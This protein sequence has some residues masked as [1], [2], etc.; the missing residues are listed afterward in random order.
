M[1]DSSQEFLQEQQLHQSLQQQEVEQEETTSISDKLCISTCHTTL[2][3]N[4][5]TGVTMWSSQ[6]STNISQV[7]YNHL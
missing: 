2:P 4:I 3:E 5:V 7:C 6:A 1:E